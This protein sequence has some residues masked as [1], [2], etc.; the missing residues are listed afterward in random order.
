MK[1]VMVIQVRSKSGQDPK[2]RATLEALGLGKIGKKKEFDYTPAVQG[3]VRRVKHLVQV[4][5][6]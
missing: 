1:K 3:M 5:A 2:C 4:L 6:V